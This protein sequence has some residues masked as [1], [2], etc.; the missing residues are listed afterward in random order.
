MILSGHLVITSLTQT[1]YSFVSCYFVVMYFNFRCFCV[2]FKYCFLSFV[3][4]SDSVYVM[5][6]TRY[7]ETQMIYKWHDLLT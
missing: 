7:I 4:L 2:L 6:N 5:F 3:Y 1:D